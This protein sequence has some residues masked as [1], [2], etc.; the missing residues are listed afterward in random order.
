[1]DIPQLRLHNQHITHQP[2]EQPAALVKWMGAL[3]GQDYPGAKWSIGLR[4]PGSTDA[5]VEQ[6]IADQ[7]I[8][9]T[10]VMRG[11]L[12]LVTAED[13]RWMVELVAPGQIHANTRRYKQLELDDKTLA[14]SS[15]IIAKAVQNQPLTRR[16][17]LEALEQ[18]GI[19]TAGQRGVYMLQRASLDGLV[20]QTI[21]QGNNNPT[22]IPIPKAKSMPKNEAIAELAQRYFNSHGPA[23]LKDFTRWSGLSA[24]DARAGFEAIK[25]KLSELEIDGQS[26]WHTE[27][28]AASKPGVYLLSAF[29]EYLLGYQDRS[30]VLDTRHTKHI[31]PGGGTFHPAI[32]TDGQVVG[33]WQAS[34]KKDTI[35]ITPSLFGDAPADDALDATAQAYGKFMGLPAVVK[36]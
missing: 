36:S 3:Q 30:A 17:L 21:M 31:F 35:T 10:W 26:Y 28:K 25:S 2:F 27:A 4:L 13:L 14:R 23:T 9:R 1:M 12:H 5:A 32:V 7:R 19:S 18:E 8:L 16:Q 20:A 11:T 15:D 34:V 33:R 22:F 29:D 24:A 6:A